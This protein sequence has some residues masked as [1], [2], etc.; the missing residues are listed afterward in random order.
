MRRALTGAVVLATAAGVVHA[1]VQFR[2]G[3]DVVTLNVAV[4]NG[5]NVVAGLTA[6]DFEV[7]DNGVPQQVVSLAHESW[8]IDVTLLIHTK[9]ST[10]WMQGV[11]LNAVK[12]IQERL[13]PEDRLALVTFDQRIRE[14]LA[15]QRAGQIRDFQFGP[16]EGQTSMYDALAV[17]LAA[18]PVTERRQIAI[19]FV[20]NF[21]TTSLL[22]EADVLEL[23]RRSPTAM[24]FVSQ[25]F[26][27]GGTP[28]GYRHPL[29][30]FHRVAAATGGV[31]Q[32]GPS[33][34]TTVSPRSIRISP[35]R[36]L[37]D[38]PFI[39]SLDEFRASYVLH[40][41]LTGVPR[42][43]WHEVSVKIKRPDSAEYRVRTRNGYT[44]DD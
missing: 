13:K 41:S 39:R 23:A 25:I 38:E 21:D 11:V 43:G 12:R 37:L 26:T 6:A 3:V 1:Q 32:V 19:V 20:D 34:R 35:N 16:A 15:L 27:M 42:A 29:A 10:S 30:F 17:V 4:T 9:A 24:F 2:S 7:L 18:R 44:G 33:H 5:Q 36:N 8:P 22:N 40:Y 31:V 14:R 28:P